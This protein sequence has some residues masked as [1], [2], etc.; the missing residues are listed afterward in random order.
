MIS[1][2][3]NHFGDV[4]PRGR[5]SQRNSKLEENGESWWLKLALLLVLKGAASPHNAQKRRVAGTLA[6]A[7][8]PARNY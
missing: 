5:F 7:G 4:S 6:E 8:D 1:R 3:K 2:L